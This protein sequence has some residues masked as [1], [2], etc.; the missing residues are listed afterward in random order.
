M[1]VRHFLAC[2]GLALGAMACAPVL[3]QTAGAATDPPSADTGSA[4]F[5]QPVAAETLATFRGGA[6][7]RNTMTLDG[8]TAD[9]SAYEVT[10][11]SN[12][13]GT[14]SFANM[15]GLPIVIQNSGANVLIQN[16]VILNVQMD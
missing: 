9:N 6:Q 1:T 2:T 5:A 4:L 13:I 3:A 14:G 10:T 7:V 16:A 15:S 12:S 11:G 8:V